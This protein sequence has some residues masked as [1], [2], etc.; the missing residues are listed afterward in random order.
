MG[1]GREGDGNHRQNGV[2]KGRRNERS[3]KGVVLSNI[4]GQSESA[5]R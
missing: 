4:L 2:C 1:T 5:L 3:R